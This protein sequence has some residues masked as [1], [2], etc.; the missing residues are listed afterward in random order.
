MLQID[1]KN[2]F[3]TESY[4][5]TCQTHEMGFFMKIVGSFSLFPQNTPS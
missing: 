4:F 3:E 5:G 1:C 2:L